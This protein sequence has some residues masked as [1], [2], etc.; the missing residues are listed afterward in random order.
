MPRGQIF[1]LSLTALRPVGYCAKL[2]RIYHF[3]QQPL[4]DIKY[5]FI[6]SRVPQTLVRFSQKISCQENSF[7]GSRQNYK[8]PQMAKFDCPTDT[9]RTFLTRLTR[10]RSK[11][12]F[13]SPS[14]GFRSCQATSY[15]ICKQNNHDW[16][17]ASMVLALHMDLNKAKVLNWGNW[18]VVTACS[19]HS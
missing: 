18:K 12:Y 2:I 17:I 5:F 6:T 16:K 9:W 13:R 8:I 4:K 14:A 3:L 1:K 7:G 19:E 10:S 15:K 11:R